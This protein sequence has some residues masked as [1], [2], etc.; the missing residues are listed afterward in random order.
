MD[1]GHLKEIHPAPCGRVVARGPCAERWGPHQPGVRPRSYRE[2]YPG[3]GGLQGP[4]PRAGQ[5]G[6]PAPRGLSYNVW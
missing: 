2:G 3:R 4:R 1:R 6:R 5:L